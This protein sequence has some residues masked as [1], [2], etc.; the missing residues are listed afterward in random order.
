MLENNEFEENLQSESEQNLQSESE[1]NMQSE[2]EPVRIA[3]EVNGNQRVKAKRKPKQIMITRRMAA[4]TI[5]L[6][7][8]FSSAFGFAGGMLSERFYPSQ[9]IQ[10]SGTP[11]SIDLNEDADTVTGTQGSLTVAEIAALTSDS[12]VEIRTETVTTD[13]FFGQFV[14]EGAGSGVIVTQDGYIVTNNHV[15]NNA[16]KITVILKNQ[17]TYDA[18][19]IGTDSKTDVAVLKIDENGLQPAIFGDSDQLKVGDMSVAIGNPLG[20]LGGTVTDGI[21]SSLDR[22]ITVE[23]KSMNLLQTNAAINPGNSGGGLFNN[24][25]ELIGIVVA[26]SAGSGVE[27]LGFAIPSNDAKPVMKSL[28]DYGFVKGR[29][30]LGVTLVDV[31]NVQTARMYGVEQ[32]G[33]YIKDVTD[34]SNAKK[35]GLNPGD[36]IMAVGDKEILSASQ[37]STEL[38]AY[39]VGDTVEVTITRDGTVKTLSIKITEYNPNK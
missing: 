25:G 39:E 19:L 12:V 5:I 16:S 32:T 13:N 29:V 6:S 31:D 26:K 35:G 30:F 1:Q 20:Q 14:S 15:I 23:G 11:V 33:V 4:M 3:E 9:G 36:R 22:E 34:G 17:K 27:G 7:V 8:L 2:C 37:V 38:E 18:D 10:N 24:K 28:M 21:I